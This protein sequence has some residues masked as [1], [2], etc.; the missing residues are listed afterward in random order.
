M[1]DKSYVALNTTQINHRYTILDIR[2]E[3]KALLNRLMDFGFSRNAQIVRLYSSLCKGCSV[4]KIKGCLIALRD[5]DAS[6]I[7]V[8]KI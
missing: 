1:N 6:N 2:C 8:S 3:N 7:F 5:K 4:Y